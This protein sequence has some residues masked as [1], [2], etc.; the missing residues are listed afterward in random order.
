MINRC[1]RS[2]TFCAQSATRA[3]DPLV[4][5]LGNERA[6]KHESRTGKRQISHAP[7]RLYGDFSGGMAIYID[8]VATLFAY[9]SRLLSMPM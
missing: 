3:D 5:M 1:S 7:T 6:Y 9:L 2:A 4:E 8:T